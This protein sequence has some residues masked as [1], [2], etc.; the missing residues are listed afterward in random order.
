MAAKATEKAAADRDGFKHYS[1]YFEQVIVDAGSVTWPN[2]QDIC[3]DTLYL[4]S[5][6]A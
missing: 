6:R 1:G 3:P 5:V 2:E 4:Y